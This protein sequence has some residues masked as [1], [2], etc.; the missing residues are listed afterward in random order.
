MLFVITLS[1]F[2]CLPAL[3]CFLL[4]LLFV[5]LLVFLCF[6]LSC[7]WL[8]GL[9]MHAHMLMCTHTCMY[10]DLFVGQDLHACGSWFVCLLPFACLIF[11]CFSFVFCLFLACVHCWFF[12]FVLL[13]V[14]TCFG[15]CLFRFLFVCSFCLFLLLL[16]SLLLP[17]FCL[18]C[19]FCLFYTCTHAHVHMCTCRLTHS[20]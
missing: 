7:S 14:F 10:I 17:S 1:L 13:F 4:F 20:D 11:I 5:L 12:L 19:L 15:C 8:F 16:N 9:H 18:F 3:V 2:A 6:F